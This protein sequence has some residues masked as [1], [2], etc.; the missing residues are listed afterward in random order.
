LREEDTAQY[1]DRKWSLERFP[2]RERVR[3][4]GSEGET[5]FAEEVR[6]R[7]GGREVL[8]LGCG[9]GRFTLQIAARAK[10]VVGVDISTTALQLANARRRRSKLRNVR[11]RLAKASK[12]PYP[13]KRFDVVYSRRGPGTDSLRT[14]S[15]AYRVLRPGGVFLEITIGERDKQNIA[16]IF[17]RGQMLKVSG[18]VS[19]LKR[20]MLE[21]VGFEQVVARD[22]LATEVFHAMPDLLVRLRT[23][24]IIPRFNEVRDRKSL[25]RV[26][27]LCRT[28]RG[29]E[30]PVHRVILIA[31]KP[32]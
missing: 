7:T 30:T 20:R 15:E 25:E 4:D 8:D 21:R 27:R 31:R 13:S 5:E 9:P 12:L 22:Y 26:E 3:V 2:L 10:R 32:S 24:P 29:I 17:G 16:R 6:R 28:E 14:L 11:F 18:Q 1:W 19:L 23:A